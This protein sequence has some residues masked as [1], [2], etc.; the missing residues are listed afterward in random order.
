MCKMHLFLRIPGIDHTYTCFFVAGEF[1]QAEGKLVLT[2][3]ANQDMSPCVNYSVAI[4]VINPTDQSGVFLHRLAR[5]ID[6]IYAITA[7]LLL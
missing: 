2:V 3:A 5:A 4:T 6:E 1:M 7:R